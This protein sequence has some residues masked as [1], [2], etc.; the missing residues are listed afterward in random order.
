MVKYDVIFTYDI[1]L[2]KTFCYTTWN[3]NI[4]AITIICVCTGLALVSY[5]K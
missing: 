3:R 4:H 2:L 1:Y 5:C